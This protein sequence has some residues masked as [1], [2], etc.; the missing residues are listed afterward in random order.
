[1][2]QNVLC[3][4]ARGEFF[5]MILQLIEILQKCLL[6]LDIRYS[7][8]Y[9]KSFT[10]KTT[11]EA[12]QTQTSSHMPSCYRLHFSILTLVYACICSQFARLINL[13][14]TT[15]PCQFTRY[16]AKYISY[17]SYYEYVTT[18]TLSLRDRTLSFGSSTLTSVKNRNYYYCFDV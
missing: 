4:I 11:R 10:L 2:R 3:K 7:C 14:H 15:K 18:A 17:T 9:N 1:M 12:L 13:S 5:K 6:L 16:S 8:A